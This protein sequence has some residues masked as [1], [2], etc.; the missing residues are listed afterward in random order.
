MDVVLL[1]TK[2]PELTPSK[3]R[4]GALA[5]TI[6]PALLKDTCE[7]LKNSDLPV[8]AY[9]LPKET[10]SE[11]FSFCVYV[12]EQIGSDFSERLEASIEDCFTRSNASRI[13]IVGSDAPTHVQRA[14]E[15]LHPTSSEMILGPCMD[16]GFYFIGL[17]KAAYQALKPL[18]KVLFTDKPQ[19]KAFLD[20]AS[21][22]HL[23]A[24][25]LEL[26]VDV[27]LETDLALLYSIN[28]LGKNVL[29][30]IQELGVTGVGTNEKE[31]KF[32]WEDEKSGKP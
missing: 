6:A 17:S 18:R 16:G 31:I 32:V 22:K 25:I 4:L 8:Y 9:T 15:S 20:V 7:V 5:K 19:V 30:A 28:K 23:E 10:I 29:E 2:I 11:Q 3:T 27:D 26:G 1:F 14:L 13:F 12:S 21:A 24:E